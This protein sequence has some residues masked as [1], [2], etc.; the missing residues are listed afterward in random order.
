MTQEGFQLDPA[1]I[2]DEIHQDLVTPGSHLRV[3][4][5]GYARPDF[6]FGRTWQADPVDRALVMFVGTREQAAAL[7][8][9]AKSIMREEAA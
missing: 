4:L 9:A 3:H 5:D 1:A 8:D 7:A 2:A 6:N